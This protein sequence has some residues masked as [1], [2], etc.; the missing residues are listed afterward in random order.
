MKNLPEDEVVSLERENIAIP[1]TEDG[2]MP[3]LKHKAKDSVF[4]DLFGDVHYLIQLYRALHPEDTTSTEQDIA[5][6][7]IKNVGKI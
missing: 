7:T 3:L 6:V 1:A 4:T 2:G 5:N